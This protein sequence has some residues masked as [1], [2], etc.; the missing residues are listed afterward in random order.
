M[1]EPAIAWKY[2]EEDVVKGAGTP[3]FI[4][5]KPVDLLSLEKCNKMEKN[6]KQM[7]VDYDKD[8]YKAKYMEE[9]KAKFGND[10][11]HY[12]DKDSFYNGLN[13]LAVDIMWSDYCPKLTSSLGTR[14]VSG[15]LFGD[16]LLRKYSAEYGI[17]MAVFAHVVRRFSRFHNK[18]NNIIDVLL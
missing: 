12:K 15:G 17:E 10:Y 11:G 13:N 5:N 2:K 14:G 9:Y 4:R 8:S 3:D 1:T 18:K 16:A 7:A 6:W